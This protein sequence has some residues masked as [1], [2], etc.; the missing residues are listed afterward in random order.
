MKLK[1]FNINV[2]PQGWKVPE[3]SK[4]AVNPEKQ[5]AA[6][7]T[8]I[9]CP[10]CKDIIGRLAAPLFSGMHVQAEMIEWSSHQRREKGEQAFCTL[11]NAVYMKHSRSIARGL[12]LL[13][14]TPLGWL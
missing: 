4:G 11:C 9:T 14:H 5:I 6:A 10:R 7:G 12:R 1:D 3:A 8:Q 13:I 2:M